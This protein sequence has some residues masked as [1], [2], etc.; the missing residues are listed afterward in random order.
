MNC[1]VLSKPSV[2]SS[3]DGLVALLIYSEKWPWRFWE[4][5]YSSSYLLLEVSAPFRVITK[6]VKTWCQYLLFTPIEFNFIYL[7]LYDSIDYLF[8]NVL[9]K[10]SLWKKFYVT[11]SFFFVRKV[12]AHTVTFFFYCVVLPATVLVPEVEVPK[13]GSVYIPSI[14]TVLNAVGTPRS[15]S[16]PSIFSLLESKF[17]WCLVVDC[18]STG[19]AF[20][21]VQIHQ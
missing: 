18:I 14:I 20:W 7:Y 3:T 19:Q 5:R 21:P 11:Y 9:Q 1:L 17:S 12:I 6:N 8:D 4:T 13:W 10:V 15:F 16:P 2:I